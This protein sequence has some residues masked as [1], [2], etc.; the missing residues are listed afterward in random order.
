M[1]NISTVTGIAALLAAGFA[2]GQGESDHQTWMKT[3]AV[4]TARLQKDLN[5]KDAAAVA[6]DAKTLKDT[7]TLVDAFWQKRSA[8]DAVAFNKQ[9]LTALAAVTKAA[10]AGNLEQASTEAKAIAATCAGCHM[11]HREKADSGFKTK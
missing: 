5:A 6:A 3:L 11:A 4:S 9:A 10:A 8:P 2:L 1:R 7:Y